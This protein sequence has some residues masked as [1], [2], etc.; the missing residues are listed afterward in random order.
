MSPHTR[1]SLATRLQRFNVIHQP[2]RLPVEGKIVR[3]VGMTLEAVGCKIPVPP[4][5]P[6]VLV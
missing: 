6:D 3:M 5:R 4:R 1:P 2:P